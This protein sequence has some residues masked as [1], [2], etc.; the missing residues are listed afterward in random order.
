MVK[1]L[2]KIFVKDYQN[3]NDSTVREKYGLLGSFFGLVTNLVLFVS[4]IVIGILLGLFSIVT[5]SVNN[6]SDFGNNFISVI[7]VKA[8]NKKADKEH[9]FGHQRIEF[10]LSLIIACIIIGLAMV[11]MYQSI[12]D[13]VSFFKNVANEGCPPKEEISLLMF[14][15]SLCILSI[16]VLIK[17][18]QSYVYFS[19]GKRIDS[20]PLK[21]LGKDARNDVITTLFVIV[22]LLITWFSKYNFDCFFT[23]VVAIFV[24]IS[25][26]GIMKESISSLISQTPKKEIVDRL[27]NLIKSNKGVL[28]IHDLMLHY[29]GNIIY[30]VIHVEVDD[31][32]DVN[33]S[34]QMI[35]EIE[36][37]VFDKMSINLTIHMDPINIT[38]SKTNRIKQYVKD[39]LN[40]KYSNEIHMHDFHCYTKNES[41]YIE[42]DL[43]IPE[44]FDND[45]K[46]KEISDYVSFKLNEEFKEEFKLTINFD[47]L[48][49]DFLSNADIEEE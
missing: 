45:G 40:S 1:F 27:C 10:I 39:I 6:L 47:N 11:M 48:N 24:I 31:R 3:T 38:D 32:I 9:P 16:G 28:G 42:F 36:K 12:L 49:Q 7:G 15:V 43:V 26:I 2:L 37:E 20:M 25:G 46:R 13:M 22:G 30:G 17:F 14:I 33:Q 29:Y 23:L 4:K 44:S 34:H 19:L 21:A 5:D 8:S 41:T 35:D 18:I